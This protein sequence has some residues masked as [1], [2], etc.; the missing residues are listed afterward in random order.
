MRVVT[1]R[2]RFSAFSLAVEEEEEGAAG[3][4]AAG[5]AAGVDWSRVSVRSV[6]EEKNRKT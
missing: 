1:V 2:C 3:S 4:G 6:L 5:V